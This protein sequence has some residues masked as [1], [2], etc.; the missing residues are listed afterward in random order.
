MALLASDVLIEVLGLLN[1]PSG[2]VY[3]SA[4]I[5]VLMNKAYRE[6]QNKLS[7]YGIGTT[8]EI[9][10]V[11]PVLAGVLRLGDGAGLPAD[12]L[13]PNDV[14]ERA[15]GSP[16]SVYFRDMIE[17]DFDPS[18]LPA[19]DYLGS[20]TWR[21]DEIKFTASTADR[22]VLIRYTRSLG[23]ITG[24]ASPILILN[25]QQWLA[26]RTAII[27]ARAIGG[28]PSR[29]D[30]LAGDLVSLES[31]LIGPMVKRKQSIPV[32]RRRTKFRVL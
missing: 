31:D 26:Q 14:K 4:Q 15:L 21:E 30:E 32:R 3:P 7:S 19:K 6:M 28:N 25:S 11:V 9:S 10:A 22:E 20:W 23:G 1:D 2:A 12:L 5:Y 24:A 8:K 16:A 29:A 18:N 13:A 27:A 17:T